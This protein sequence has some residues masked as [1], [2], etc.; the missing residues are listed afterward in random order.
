M[1]EDAIAPPLPLRGPTPLSTPSQRWQS[2]AV[3][4]P[5]ALEGKPSGFASAGEEGRFSTR[6][7]T[8]Q[9][10]QAFDSPRCGSRNLLQTL[11]REVMG[12]EQRRKLWQISAG[13]L[14]C[15]ILHFGSP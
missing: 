9:Q 12:L 14:R 6:L 8:E 4:A 3:P 7:Y 5:R 11:G 15:Q 1:L 13:A 10:G 2:R